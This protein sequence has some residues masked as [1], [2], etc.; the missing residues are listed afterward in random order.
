MS[1]CEAQGGWEGRSKISQCAEFLY[2]QGGENTDH[3]VSDKL[4]MKWNIWL[5][6]PTTFPE[7]FPEVKTRQTATRHVMKGHKIIE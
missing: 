1:P 5:K 3:M 7:T 6:R 2:W 4:I